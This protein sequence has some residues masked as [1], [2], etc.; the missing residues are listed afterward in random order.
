[1]LLLWQWSNLIIMKR[2]QAGF[3]FI[4][5][6]VAFIVLA[7]GLLGTVAM[8]AVAK[9]NSFDAMQR[10]QAIAIAN[11]MVERIRANPTVVNNYLKA[12]H[13]GA[14]DISA[15]GNRCQNGAS[16]CSAAQIAL[17][18][19]FEWD[20]RLFGA[21]VSNSDGNI[22]GI[23]NATGCVF[24][25]NGNLTVVVSWLGKEST[26]DAAVSSGQGECGE[27][28]KERRQVVVNNFIM[29]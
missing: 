13:Y 8:Q 26:K 20:Q 17:N 23:V 6:M 18:D 14:G 15:P 4:E 3:S 12:D 9:R 28:G 16:N 11:D 24:F 10:A 19:R 29:Q 1:M 7:T 22:G 5:V 25:N 2:F 27:A 21:D